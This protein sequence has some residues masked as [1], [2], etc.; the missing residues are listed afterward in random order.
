MFHGIRRA[1]EF[2]E[3]LCTSPLLQVLT[4]GSIEAEDIVVMQPPFF[5][6]FIRNAS[7]FALGLGDTFGGTADPIAACE[8]LER[9]RESLVNAVSPYIVL[10]KIFFSV[11]LCSG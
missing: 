4:R 7:P 11:A 1:A 8:D 9:L 2:R 6:S 5:M 3:W 10:R